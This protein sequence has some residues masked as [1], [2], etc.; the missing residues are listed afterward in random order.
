MQE[1]LRPTICAEP[2]ASAQSREPRRNSAHRYGCEVVRVDANMKGA[3]ARSVV[4]VMSVAVDEDLGC[5]PFAF[6]E[7]CD[8][9]NI[10]AILHGPDLGLAQD[11]LDSLLDAASEGSYGATDIG[12]VVDAELSENGP[13][14]PP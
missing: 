7:E 3:L 10:A 6:G 5:D 12:D 8:D 2:Q 11:A 9:L 13:A 14:R 1:H 4:G